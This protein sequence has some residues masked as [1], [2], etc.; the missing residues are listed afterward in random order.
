MTNAQHTPGLWSYNQDEGGYQGHVISTGDYIICDLPDAGDGAAPHTE[1]NARLIAAAPQLFAF[2]QQIAR[3]TMDGE[4][5]NYGNDIYSDFVM[6]NDDAVATL[7]QLIEEARRLEAKAKGEVA[8]SKAT[9]LPPDPDG[10]N[11]RHAG[12]AAAAAIRDFQRA[13]GTDWCDAVA[14]LLCGLMHFCDRES[15]DFQQELDRARRY[16]KV[17][18][19]EETSDVVIEV[20][21]GVA[22]I[23]KCPAV[24]SVTIID[25]DQKGDAP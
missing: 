9:S 20:S 19:A 21:G 3:M 16:Y 7:N 15:F 22:Q 1:A 18:C 11:G 10:M 17:E 8:E 5:V 24:V 12:W 13:T 23:T 4:P 25:H 14:D 6:E 2:I